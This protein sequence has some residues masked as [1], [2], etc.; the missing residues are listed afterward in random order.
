MSLSIVIIGTGTNYFN[1]QIDKYT[2][3]YAEQEFSE[4]EMFILSKA[5]NSIYGS[6][7]SKIFSLILE[8]E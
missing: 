5:S 3:K 8:E 2:Y 7:M 6:R 4:K 1:N